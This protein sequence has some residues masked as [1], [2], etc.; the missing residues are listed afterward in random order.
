MRSDGV[1]PV[2]DAYSAAWTTR[3]SLDDFLGVD[4]LSAQLKATVRRYA[5][6]Q[7]PVLVTGESGT[8][9]EIVVQA[10]HGLSPN[11]AGPFVRVNCAAI[12][13]DLM[14]AELFG[15]EPGAFTGAAPRGAVGKVEC[16]NHGSL[17]LDE[18]AELGLDL[19]A[20]LL[21]VL[22][23]KEVVRVGGHQPRRVSF[24]LLA[25]TNRS[26][27]D[28]VGR[29]QFR[30]DLYY[31]LNMLRV[32]IPP[33]RARPRDIPDHYLQLAANELGASP[34]KILPECLA[35]LS[36]LRWPGN[37]RELQAVMT[38]LAVL[39]DAPEISIG[40]LL[41]CGREPDGVGVSGYAT[42]RTLRSV[43]RH[44]ESATI[45]EVLREAN[46]NKSRAARLLGISRSLLYY[47][48][49]AAAKAGSHPHVV[50]PGAAGET[51]G[52]HEDREVM[53]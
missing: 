1:A 37:V 11:H 29:G 48:L 24:R 51:A 53:L 10:L 4:P 18:I 31:R 34:P 19:Q 43:R 30:E 33:L 42:S 5:L 28:L 44:V 14:E 22:Q 21:R 16:A 35:Y 9:K 2:A 6:A 38:R 39:I 27:A 3:Y 52:S 7:C 12:P 47:H 41:R 25:A 8:G 32:S 26:L 50:V 23:E 17:L 20:K 13:R 15:Y 49:R 46:G 40:D 36:S 45:A